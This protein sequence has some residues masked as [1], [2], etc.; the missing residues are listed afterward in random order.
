[1]THTTRAHKFAT[2]EQRYH[3]PFQGEF[4]EGTRDMDYADIE[5]G[6]KD[7]TVDASWFCVDCWQER[8]GTDSNS[9]TREA[10]GLPAASR[11]A[12]VTDHRFHQHTTR[13][14]ICDNCETYCTGRARDYLPGSF[15]YASDNSRAGP[16]MNRRGC[17][18]SPA[19]REDLWRNGTWNARHLCRTCLV[20]EW[21]Q[22]PQEIDQ[23]LALHHTGAA[24]AAAY[25]CMAGIVQLALR[26]ARAMGQLITR[27]RMELQLGQVDVGPSASVQDAQD[28]HT[29]ALWANP[30][31][32]LWRI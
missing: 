29:R 32:S 16:P 30:F 11:P 17:F 1:M 21:E 2:T 10:I 31:L 12:E 3:G 28:Q 27:Q 15:V 8:L 19:L 9:S 25:Q 6:W 4:I 14:S 20:R 7:G 13:W 24:K 23:W 5:S 22:S 18:P 26:V